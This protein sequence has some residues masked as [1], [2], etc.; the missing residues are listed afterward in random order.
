MAD[1]TRACARSPH[2]P[3]L[4]HQPRSVGPSPGSCCWPSCCRSACATPRRRS[5]PPRQPQLAVQQRV[6]LQ[7]RRRLAHQ[8]RLA[9]ARHRDAQRRRHLR[10]RHGHRRLPDLARRRRTPGR[11]RCTDNATPYSCSWDTTGV[12][13]GLR[14]IRAVATDTA[15]YTQT[16]TVTNRRID[17]T[18]P[19]ATTTDPGSPLTGTV[20]GHGQRLRPAGSGVANTTVQY[21]PCGGGSW[22]DLCTQAGGHRHLLVEHRFARD[23]LYDLRTIATD[24]AGNT[25]RPRPSSPTAASTTSRRPRR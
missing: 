23:G 6:E 5:W 22:T 3:S 24:V 14:D 21:R 15:G 9:A 20:I 16:A 13:D 17:N 18:G 7:H 2:A 1:V 12:A 25:G 4:P 19:T 11:P 10:P 8:P